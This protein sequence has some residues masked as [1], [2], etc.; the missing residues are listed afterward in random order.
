MDGELLTVFPS[1][2]SAVEEVNG[3]ERVIQ[4]IS[5]KNKGGSCYGYMWRRDKY[6][7]DKIQKYKRCAKKCKSV[8]NYK[9][10]KK[11][12]DFLSIE[13]ATKEVGACPG[14]IVNCIKGRSKSCRGYQWKYK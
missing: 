11:I 4:S 9:N 7:E 12:K 2:E 14:A 13:E 1:L 5:T 8:S 6:I 10:G 3:D